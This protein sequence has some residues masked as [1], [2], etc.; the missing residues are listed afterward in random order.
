M[1]KLRLYTVSY[2]LP[3]YTMTEP[4]GEVQVL[5]WN[6]DEALRRAERY[7]INFLGFHG[8]RGIRYKIVR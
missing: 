7:V 6:E 5:A 3:A 4:G 8:M 2:D 1:E